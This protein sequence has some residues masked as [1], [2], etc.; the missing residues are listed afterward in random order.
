[1]L[2]S[3]VAQQSE[4]FMA[5]RCLSILCACDISPIYMLWT[6][7]APGN[8]IRQVPASAGALLY[9]SQ[10]PRLSYHGETVNVPGEERIWKVAA[11]N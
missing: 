4:G 5:A 6:L 1:M 2:L 8:S 10:E 7:E 3:I 9:G 11:I